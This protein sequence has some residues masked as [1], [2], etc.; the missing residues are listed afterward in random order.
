[1]PIQ[2][3]GGTSLASP[4]GHPPKGWRRAQCQALLYPPTWSAQSCLV[5]QLE[6]TLAG[7]AAVAVG[8]RH[9]LRPFESIGTLTDGR[10]EKAP[11]RGGPVNPDF[12]GQEVQ[13]VRRAT[14]RRWMRC[15]SMSSSSLLSILCRVS[16]AS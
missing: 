3:A 14:G 5:W 15:F 7:P 4:P 6:R 11:H 16:V 10:G 8:M 1:M 13:R 9:R 2:A 12:T